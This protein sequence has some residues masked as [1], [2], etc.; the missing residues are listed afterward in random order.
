MPAVLEKG[1]GGGS[2]LGTS[3]FKGGP[4]RET[5]E[6]HVVTGFERVC[7][8]G[9]ASNMNQPGV[10]KLGRARAIGLVPGR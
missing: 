9:E 10:V 1:N 2:V 7:M 6:W 8:H 3:A 5:R 4:K